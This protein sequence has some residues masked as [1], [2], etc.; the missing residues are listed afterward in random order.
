MDTDRREVERWRPGDE[1]PEIVTTE[2]VWRPVASAPT[3]AI[4][5]EPLFQVVWEGL[6][7]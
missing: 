5:L 4:A 6:E 1:S 7:R 2:L 3:L